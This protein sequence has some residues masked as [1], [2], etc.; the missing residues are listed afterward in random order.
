M[1][2][3][4]AI[5]LSY[6]LPGLLLASLIGS[7]IFVPFTT[8]IL[9]PVLIKASISP[10]EIVLYAAFG[11]LLGTIVNYALGF[12][13]TKLVQKHI[14]GANADKAQSIMDKYGWLGLFVIMVV[15]LPLPVD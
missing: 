3:L 11:S 14:Q 13:G 9:F 12:Y 10:V 1:I 7:T 6:G 8:E 4:Y 15:P 2:D 5:V